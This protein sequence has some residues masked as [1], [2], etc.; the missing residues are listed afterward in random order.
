MQD[1]LVK[2]NEPHNNCLGCPNFEL[3]YVHKFELDWDAV[4]HEHANHE[5]Y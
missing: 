5:K 3:P 2:V 1:I 4:T